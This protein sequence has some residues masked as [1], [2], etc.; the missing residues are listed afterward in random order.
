MVRGTMAVNICRYSDCILC[1]ITLSLSEKVLESLR[2]GFMKCVVAKAIAHE[3]VDKNIIPET[4]ET[5]IVN[6]KDKSSANHYLFV[7]L[8][9]QVTV[10]DLRKLCSIMKD[11]EGYRIMNGFGETLEA[12]LDKVSM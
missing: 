10:E 9:S 12:E 11:A 3:A 7:H 2:D 1:L 8:R 6:A 4:V 5:D